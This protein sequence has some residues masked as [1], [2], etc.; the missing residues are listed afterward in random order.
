MPDPI[1]L[2]KAM[3]AAAALAAVI[4]WGMSRFPAKN[5]SALVTV[6]WVLGVAVG[7]AMGC[8]VL[9]LVPHWPPAEV[10]DRFVCLV[11]PAVCV[12]EIAGGI[13]RVPSWLAWVLRALLAIAIPRVILHG[14]VYLSD[15]TGPESRQWTP[16][17]AWLIMTAIGLGLFV[18]W[19]VLA[20]L[21]RGST[22]SV[23]PAAVALTAAVSGVAIML[24][25]YATGGQWGL[26]LGAAIGGATLAS[27]GRLRPVR[28]GGEEHSA[29]LA[30]RDG[31]RTGL[32]GSEAVGT[33]LVCLFSL[34]MMGRFLSELSTAHAVLLLAAPLGL[35]VAV[36]A[37]RRLPGWLIGALGLVLVAIPLGLVLY[38]AQRTFAERS[39]N[40]AP[41]AESGE[42]SVGDYL[43]LG[44]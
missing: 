39:A 13:G 15:L 42:T 1:Q 3:G 36:P 7:F 11:L 43:N 27:I 14:S 33:G 35:A 38:Q 6:G 21:A 25:G 30:D 4:L 9:G 10:R 22:G 8:W 31:N 16:V 28:H 2:V 37:A 41:A 17:Q 20:R 26:P 24:S 18:V 29:S 5:R 12:I 23:V 44:R 40:S 34:V 32:A 19:G